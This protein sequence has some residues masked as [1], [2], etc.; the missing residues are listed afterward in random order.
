MLLDI[1]LPPCPGPV[2]REEK[3]AEQT[4]PLLGSLANSGVSDLHGCQLALHREVDVGQVGGV[5]VLSQLAGQGLQVGRPL[6]GGEGDE[7]RD[8]GEPNK[9]VLFA[10]ISDLSTEQDNSAK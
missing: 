1:S 6:R 10:D 9:H 8:G 2:A 3:F 4:G 7:A 5:V